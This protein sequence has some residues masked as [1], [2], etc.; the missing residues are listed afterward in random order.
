[1][2]YWIQNK[3]AEQNFD[4]DS[5]KLVVITSFMDPVGTASDLLSDRGSFPGVPRR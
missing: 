3:S 2:V 1:M 5:V 4:R